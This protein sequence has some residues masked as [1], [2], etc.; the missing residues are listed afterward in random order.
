[1]GFNLLF[2]VFFY[3]GCT[4]VEVTKTDVQFMSLYTQ[5]ISLSQITIFI[6]KGIRLFLL[7]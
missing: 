2:G 7:I 4:K 6:P 1:M 5:L 3:V